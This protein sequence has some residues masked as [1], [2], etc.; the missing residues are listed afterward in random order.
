M[1]RRK[2][3]RIKTLTAAAAAGALTLGAGTLLAQQVRA[4]RRP[5]RRAA[6][7]AQIGLTDQQVAAI[8]KARL[9]E[10]KAEIRRRA[11]TQ[12]AR[13]ELRELLAA[14]TLDEAAISAH[15]K[16]L[17]EL[18][19]AGVRARAE[20]QLAVRRLVSAEQYEK[21]QEMRTRMGAERARGVRRRFGWTARPDGATDAGPGQPP[22]ANDPE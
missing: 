22:G 4:E 14:P 17:A 12:I 10:R 8:R 16:T 15:V 18:E 1:N 19:A 11:D 3:M 2:T 20:S 6:I 21:M 9:D 13:M 7:Q 5:D